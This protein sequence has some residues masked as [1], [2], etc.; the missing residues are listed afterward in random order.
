M[1]T[2]KRIKDKRKELTSFILSLYRFFTSYLQLSAANRALQNHRLHNT[3]VPREVT[4]G[5]KE[6]SQGHWA[7]H[8]A[9]MLPLLQVLS[10]PEHGLSSVLSVSR[11]PK[12]AALEYKQ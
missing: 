7:Q 3:Q 9:Y 6:G 2:R 5:A 11:Q 1:D 12:I 10:A 4:S 8:G